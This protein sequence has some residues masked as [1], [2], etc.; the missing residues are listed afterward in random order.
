ML[1]TKKIPWYHGLL[2]LKRAKNKNKNKVTTSPKGSY[3]VFVKMTYL[4]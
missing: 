3:R 4:H 2:S 1:W